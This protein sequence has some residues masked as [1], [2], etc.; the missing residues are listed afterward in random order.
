MCPPPVVTRSDNRLRNC[1]I[2]RPTNNVLTN[3]LPAGLHQD[4]FQLLNVSNATTTVNK[5]LERSHRSNG[6]LGLSLG[7]SAANFL[8]LQILSREDAKLQLFV[9]NDELAHHPVEK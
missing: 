9:V 5:L 3:L 4:L 6:P 1:S 2:A 8:V 7:Y